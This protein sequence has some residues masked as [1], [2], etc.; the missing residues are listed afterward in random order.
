M[1]NNHVGSVIGT[2]DLNG[3]QQEGE[4]YYPFGDSSH[5]WNGNKQQR[6]AGKIRLSW[7]GYY[8]FG[9]R[10]YIPWLAKFTS[11][12]PLAAKYAHLNPYNYASNNPVTHRDIDGMQN[13]A[14]PSSPAGGNATGNQPNGENQLFDSNKVH[15]L[16]N[17]SGR[18]LGS[19]DASER[20]SA[21]FY[22][23]SDSDFSNLTKDGNNFKPI[24]EG[25]PYEISLSN[26]ASKI[27]INQDKIN[28]DIRSI[29]TPE[30]NAEYGNFEKS[31]YIIFDRKANEITSVIN[32]YVD[33]IG[34]HNT[35]TNS[36]N[37]FSNASS[38]FTT[39]MTDVSKT[40][41]AQMHT[42]PE[43]VLNKSIVSYPGASND[44]MK[45]TGKLKAPVY[46]I[47]TFTSDPGGSGNVYGINEGQNYLET[48]S[49][50]TSA[51]NIL[52][53]SFSLV[54]DIINRRR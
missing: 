25:K 13:P 54:H 31:M 15:L 21:G 4:D 6:F 16:S 37:P 11:V 33:D 23:M 34:V 22:S 44:D 27:T 43:S 28:S 52:D 53:S 20:M 50:I 36:N 30:N 3:T 46:A 9:A 45:T 12:D 35:E 10:Q 38:K 7:T 39:L 40:I 2:Y 29:M 17:T 42:H 41:L 1:I 18:Y 5:H 26:N 47:S 24:N 32:P 8:D 14:E 49:P 19:V 51:S 48:K